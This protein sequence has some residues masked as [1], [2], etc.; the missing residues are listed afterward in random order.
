MTSPRFCTLKLLMR[1]SDNAYSNLLL[2][3]S[4]ESEEFDVR[5]KKFISTLFYGVIERKLTL[6]H[7]IS[8]YKPLN[9]ID[10]DILCVLRMGI[11]QLLYMS[12]IPDNAAVNESVNLVKQLRKT[13]ASGFVNAVLRNFIRDDKK[14]DLP[15]DKIERL[16]IEYSCP[17]WLV[18]MWIDQYGE[19]DAVNI[20]KSTVS[21]PEIAVRVNTIKITSD[22]LIKRLEDEGI[23]AEKHN[24]SENCLVLNNSGAIEK[25]ESFR[26]GLF[27]VQDMSS[28]LCCKVLNPSETDIVLD[29]CAAPGGKSFT[30]AE[31]MNNKGIIYSC[32]LHEKRVH[33]IKSGAER[34]GI[35]N[36]KFMTNNA[37]E[38]NPELPLADKIL[39]DVPCAG[40]GVISKKPEIKY[41]AESE[42]SSL[43][44][45]Q[46]EILK[47]ASKYLKIGGELVYSTCSLNKEENDDV[48]DA[49]L[50]EN[51]NYEGVSF[52]EDIKKSSDGYKMTIFPDDFNS[53]GFFISKIR[54]I[55]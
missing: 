16:S 29:L 46:Y 40:L 18:K 31:L 32:D 36:I 15:A 26:N 45:I 11:Y 21:K 28:Q 3:N 39:C 41:K 54:R 12:S 38:Y 37:K 49:F 10:N 42:I 8:K 51:K 43:P 1:M 20:L 47:T 13:S 24:M 55:K 9:K 6:D 17:E 50:N 23:T 2:D 4:L 7:I 30:L 19:N 25:L 33:L 34:L 52:F 27:H 5:D 48:I 35:T 44:K 14:I 22:D 53:D